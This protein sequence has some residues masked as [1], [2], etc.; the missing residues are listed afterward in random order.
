M[1]LFYSWKEIFVFFL[2]ILIILSINLGL[3]YNKFIEF[4]NQDYAFL[5][6]KIEKNYSKIGKRR[7]K[8][9]VLK[10][11]A[12]DF[13]FYTTTKKKIN[14]NNAKIGVVT[15]NISFIDFIKKSF[16]LT[17]FKIIA[18]KSKPN[19][20][21]NLHNLVI[22]QHSNL[23]MQELFSALFLATPISN[24]L[25]QIVTNWGVA[26]IVSI[27][28]FHLSLLFGIFLFILSPIYFY[29]QDR[30]FPFRDRIFD[31][32]LLIFIFAGFYLWILDFTPSFL[33][34]YIMGVGGFFFVS[35]G[36][37]VINFENLFICLLLAISFYPS[38]A[39]SVGFYFSSLGVFSIFLFVKHFGDRKAFSSWKVLFLQ[40]LLL[41][42]FVFSI[43]NTP[44]YYFFHRAGIFQ[45]SVIP[46][47]YV[48]SVF[49]P[50]EIVLH[51]FGFGDLLDEYLL[52]FMD[53]ASANRE[54]YT[55]DYLFWG[56]NLSLIFAIRYKFVALALAFVGLF[57]YIFGLYSF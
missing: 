6:V 7:N 22:S 5:D 20:R 17:N 50:L 14:F 55:P 57:L 45:L 51:L 52:K 27:S 8:Y 54:I 13:S 31:L 1:K 9:Y 44:V 19:L 4:K 15:K 32:S 26:H 11:K 43:M 42:L 35:K 37:K 28:G 53:L 3:K 48:F 56:F 16:Y 38:L 2:G 30:F 29:F 46:L 49:Y 10:C 40:G 18:L 21:S 24:E 41:E 36:L 12:E 39:F 23:R 25:R 47:G 34:S 33:R